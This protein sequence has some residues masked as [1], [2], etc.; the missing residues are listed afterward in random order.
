MKSHERVKAHILKNAKL[1]R[2]RVGE[3][4]DSIRTIARV[5][6]VS[7]LTVS[8]AVQELA[9]EGVLRTENGRGCFLTSPSDRKTKQHTAQR[10]I[11]AKRAKATDKR[12][13]GMLL[14]GGSVGAVGGMQHVCFESMQR[15]LFDHRYSV[16]LLRGYHSDKRAYP[17][18]PPEELPLE[19]LS[20]LVVIGIYDLPYIAE[21]N[22]VGFPVVALD[23]DA[24]PVFA[25][26]VVMDHAGS[27]AAMVKK[28]HALGSRRIAFCG[29]PL[30]PRKG[31]YRF[32]YDPSAPERLT[33]WRVG[34]VSCGL[35]PRDE[36]VWETST[37]T[38]HRIMTLLERRMLARDRPDAVVTEFPEKAL[39]ALKK[40]SLDG[41][42]RVAGWHPGDTQPAFD[43]IDV[44][45]RCELSRMAAAGTQLLLRRLKGDSEQIHRKVIGLEIEARSSGRGKGPRQS[46]R[47]H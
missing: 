10:V 6:K 40:H 7:T 26:S 22:E 36:W 12:I 35:E 37:R 3:K 19:D 47:G 14:S 29:G 5:T 1:G 27:A 45:A 41:R 44:V 8:R 21:L 43:E 2:Y 25:D 31:K 24:T 34:M 46:T 18:V 4:I 42:V 15:T 38:E 9:D 13:I 32:Y 33:G 17:F 20:G 28:L 16:L 11:G 30:H 23:V 39:Q